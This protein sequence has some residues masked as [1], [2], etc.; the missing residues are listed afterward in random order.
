MVNEKNMD[1]RPF[2]PLNADTDKSLIY[3]LNEIPK[4]LDRVHQG[5]P[6][7]CNRWTLILPFLNRNGTKKEA[8][9]IDNLLNTRA[10]SEA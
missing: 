2:Y 5:Q 7:V 8:I 4:P 3:C 9:K 10:V 6:V 1:D